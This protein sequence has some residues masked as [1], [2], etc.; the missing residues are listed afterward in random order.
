MTREIWDI[1]SDDALENAA[2]LTN[3]DQVA[4]ILADYAGVSARLVKREPV[5]STIINQAN[6]ES[7]FHE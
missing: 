6:H 2:I 4:S 1:P 7:R 3:D 5:N